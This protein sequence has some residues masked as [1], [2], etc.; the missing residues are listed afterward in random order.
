MDLMWLCLVSV[1]YCI[2][3]LVLELSVRCMSNMALC[4]PLVLNVTAWIAGCRY[5]LG[6]VSLFELGSGVVSVFTFG[7]GVWGIVCFRIQY[8]SSVV[9]VCGI[10]MGGGFL[11]DM[12]HGIGKTMLMRGG[13]CAAELRLMGAWFGLGC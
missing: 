10:D 9:Y 6:S 12:E 8:L 5:G 4:M 11:C 2:V 13:A 3:G 7:C 1:R